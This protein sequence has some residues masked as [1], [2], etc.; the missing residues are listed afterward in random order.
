MVGGSWL[1]AQGWLGVPG[2]APGPPRGGGF[3]GLGGVGG[4]RAPLFYLL[5]Y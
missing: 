3:G 2:R 1:M 4:P 5:G